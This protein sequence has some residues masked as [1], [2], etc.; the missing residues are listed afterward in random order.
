MKIDKKKIILGTAQFFSS[1]GIVNENKK[2]TK[3]HFY[4]ILELAGKNNIFSYDTAP[5]YKSEK[6]LGDFILANQF[7]GSKH[8]YIYK[9]DI[10]GLGYYKDYNKL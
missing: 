1:Y 3:K 8:G 10:K 5:G 9:K 7:Q 4:E 6:F 2:Q